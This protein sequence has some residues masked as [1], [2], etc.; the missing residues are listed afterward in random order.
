M[1]RSKTKIYRMNVVS[2]GVD[3]ISRM[4]LTEV[5][6]NRQ[7]AYLKQCVADSIADGSEDWIETYQSAPGNFTT[8]SQ[9]IFSYGHNTIVL[10]K[11]ECVPGCQFQN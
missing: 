6:F 9:H 7:L 4:T 8:T 3:I 5:E 2:S 1:A 11:V 10:T